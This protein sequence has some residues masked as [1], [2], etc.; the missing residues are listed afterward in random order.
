MNHFNIHNTAL[1]GPVHQLGPLPPYVPYLFRP[2]PSIHTT[3][4][5]HPSQFPPERPTHYNSPQYN[6]SPTIV[7]PRGQRPKTSISAIQ[8]IHDKSST[9][10]LL[11]DAMVFFNPLYITRNS[12][13]THFKFSAPKDVAKNNI[14]F[15]LDTRNN[16]H[17]ARRPP[18]L[19]PTNSNYHTRRHTTGY[20]NSFD[21]NRHTHNSGHSMANTYGAHNTNIR[22]SGL[23][24]APMLISHL[25]DDSRTSLDM[26][27]DITARTE[28]C[29]FVSCQKLAVICASD[30]RPH[31]S[32]T[33]VI[34]SM[35]H[36]TITHL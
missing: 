16:R 14:R 11:P 21:V 12:I 1:P 33:K 7:D 13:L 35:S 29:H 26:H 27:D 36:S 19:T 15:T 30:H 32:R 25:H 5:Y 8:S 31:N 2:T 10:I 28:A 22:S 18:L 20:I 3:H 17:T 9:T 34:N 4:F 23:R 6:V 24:P